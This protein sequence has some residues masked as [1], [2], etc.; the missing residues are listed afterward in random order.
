M[1]S[2][3]ARLAVEIDGARLGDDEAK[4]VWQRFSEFMDSTNGDA[5]AFALQEGVAAVVPKTANGQA[6]LVVTSKASAPA[7]R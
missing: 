2:T 7:K 3:K 4:E 6:I 5:I 1:A